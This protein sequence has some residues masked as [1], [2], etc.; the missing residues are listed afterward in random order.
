MRK[1][2]RLA[3]GKQ[4]MRT[5]KAGRRRLQTCQ[6]DRLAGRQTDRQTDTPDKVGR[7]TNK[8]KRQLTVDD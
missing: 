2:D 6:R 7:P 5:D 8:S 4:T 3:T 1:G